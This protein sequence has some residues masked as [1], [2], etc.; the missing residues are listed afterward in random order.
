MHMCVLQSHKV[1]LY[2]STVR[3]CAWEQERVVNINITSAWAVDREFFDIS[4]PLDSFGFLLT[5][6][7]ALGVSL[8]TL[9]A[10]VVPLGLPLAGLWGPSG[11]P[12]PF[13]AEL[14]FIKITYDYRREG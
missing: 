12:G 14:G 9:W 8:G 10:P 13:G 1:L 11:H 7:G 3:F 4:F 2:R 6:L 5:L